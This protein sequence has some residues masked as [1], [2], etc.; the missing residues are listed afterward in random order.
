MTDIQE[1][2]TAQETTNPPAKVQI[3]INEGEQL[4]VAKGSQIRNPFVCQNCGS[5]LGSV[6]TE[7]VRPGV[8][9]SALIVLRMAV[10]PAETV[11]TSFLFSKLYA[12]EVG[13]SNC[14]QVRLWHPTAET[15]EH[16]S[17]ARKHARKVNRNV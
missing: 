5:I 8:S 14:G 17:G 12:G 7:K 3:R 1:Q 2:A 11:P 9:V 16:L 10:R 6:I 4:E 15:L 13:C